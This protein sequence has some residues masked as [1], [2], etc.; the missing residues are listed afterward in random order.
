[1]KTK[2]EIYAKRLLKLADFLQKLSPERFDINDWV[3]YGWKGES[4][5]S[6]GTVACG[7]GW[8][9][10]I[11]EFRKLGLKMFQNKHRT[12]IVG[13]TDSDL[14]GDIYPPADAANKIFGLT[15]YEFN[16][17]FVPDLQISGLGKSLTRI[18]TSKQAAKHIRKFVQKKYGNELCCGKNG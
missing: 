15:L 18:S 6:C 11:P 10:T 1:M 13:L 12:G 9:T 7:L 14:W 17:L 5:L 3:G 4:D 2:P 8:A 16:F